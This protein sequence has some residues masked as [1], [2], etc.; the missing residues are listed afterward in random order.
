MIGVRTPEMDALSE[1][2]WEIGWAP[3]GFYLLVYERKWY[4][5]GSP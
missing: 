5:P 3:E 4:G 2:L 1:L